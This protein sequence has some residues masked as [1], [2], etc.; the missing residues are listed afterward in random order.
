MDKGV[1]LNGKYY[2]LEGLR[3]FVDTALTIPE[4]EFYQEVVLFIEEWFSPSEF[5]L[6]HTSGSTG[7]PKELKV[8]KQRMVQ[9]AQ[10]TC[11][12]F[13]LQQGDEVLLCMPIQYIAG[14]MML[15]RTLVAKLSLWV[16]LP[17]GRPL[18]QFITP[19]SFAAMVPL[20]LYNSLQFC[21]DKRRLKSIQNILVGGGAIDLTIENEIA[22]FPNA[23]YSSYGMTETV[24]HIAM[25]R[26]NGK[27]ASAWYEPFPS[28]HLKQTGAG[29]L[30]IDAPLVAEEVLIT[31]DVVDLK[32]DGRF[33]IIGRLDNIIN[34]GGVKIQAEKVEQKL[35]KLIHTPYVVTNVVDSRLGE[36]ITLLI[37]STPY[38]TRELS[39]GLKT[40][41]E[42]YEMPLHIFFVDA[43]PLTGTQ[44]IDRAQCKTVAKTQFHQNRKR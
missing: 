31:N 13:N 30:V 35:R 16:V 15:V 39:E 14:K 36:A 34:S 6:V 41:L 9:S 4:R 43:I 8:A 28:V 29:A 23:L 3:L 22:R 25:R 27:Q 32:S 37:E 10:M 1:T 12:Y 17:Q 11:T 38:P 42:P 2:S 5:V 19:L 24:S 21:E 40:L 44:K 20:Q 7:T 33:R 26:L 18:K